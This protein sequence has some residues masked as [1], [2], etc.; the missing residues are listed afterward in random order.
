[1]GI[2]VDQT[3]SP[4]LS[5]KVTYIGT[6]LPSFPQASQAIQ[7]LLE[8]PVG[9][10]RVERLT[11]RIGEERVAQRE[12]TTTA[13]QQ[14][15]L[16]ERLDD[17]PANVT[18]P[19][20]GAV[21]VDGGR[22]QQVESNP[23]SDNHWFEYKAGI[24]LELK[25]TASEIDPLPEVPQFL[26]DEAR[27][28]KLTV[29]IGKKAADPPAE[30][31]NP[32]TP[33]VDLGVI[34]NL[35]DLEGALETAA[36]QQTRVAD[37]SVRDEPLSPPVLRREVVATQH[38]SQM[39]GLL[40]VARAWSLGLF[41]STR[42][43]FV[44]DG[45]SWI[46][47]LWETHFKAAEFTPV[48]DLIHAVT[49]LYASATA[50]RPATEGWSIYQR[51]LKWVWEGNVAKV[52]EELSMRQA[53]LGSPPPDESETSPRSIVSKALTYLEN[54]QSRMNYPE[55]RKRGLPITSAHMES[56]VKEMN[57]RIK[58]SEKFWGEAGAEAMLQ[59]KADTLCDSQP[60]DTFWKDRH[61]NRTGFYSCVG[62]RTAKSTSA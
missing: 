4:A 45:S 56:T 42:K 59:M 37:K 7:K 8:L 43:A 26:L 50:G 18:P 10:K 16:T 47:G 62:S 39:M 41:Q 19:D 31:T 25:G 1:M 61:N 49:Y 46:W 58:G 22:H 33:Q 11:E 32:A 38:N 52:I 24:C 13:Y 6:I 57:R 5:D 48:L 44:G 14:L 54:Q 28:K 12:A 40:L 15:T 23:E 20:C 27:V 51:W 17:G 21:M 29:E 36:V 35:E 55:Y 30:T 34:R 3:L 2:D 60:L 9:T 53:E